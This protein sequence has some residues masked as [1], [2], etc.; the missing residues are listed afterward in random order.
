MSEPMEINENSAEEL[1][2]AKLRAQ[3]LANAFQSVL[4]QP[5]SRSEAQALVIA[6]LSKCA[7]DDK[8]SYAFGA[9]RDG[10]A[11]IGAGI[12]MDGAKSILRVIDRQLAIAANA[13]PPKA[14]KPKTRR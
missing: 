3:R 10:I 13:A 6:H 8:N 5:K 12:H 14:A 2:Q 1:K 7:S 4:G 9:A 11:I